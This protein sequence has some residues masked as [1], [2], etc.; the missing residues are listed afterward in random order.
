LRLSGDIPGG[1]KEAST[2][3]DQDEPSRLDKP[4]S[5]RGKCPFE[6]KPNSRIGESPLYGMIKKEDGDVDS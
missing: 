4:D 3:S 2:D 5:S 1:E 6:S